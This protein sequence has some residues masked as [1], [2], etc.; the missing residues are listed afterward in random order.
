[1]KVSLRHI[2]TRSAL[3]HWRR[4]SILAGIIFL[5]TIVITGS[6][7]TGYSVRAS[8]KDNNVRRLNGTEFVISSGNRFIPSSLVSRMRADYGLRLE[9]IIETKG[10]IKNFESGRALL[11]INVFGVEDSFFS[12]NPADSGLTLKQGTALVNREMAERLG[13]DSG[14]EI[15]LRTR[16]LSTIPGDSPFAPESDGYESMFLTVAGVVKDAGYENLSLGVSQLTPLNIFVNTRNISPGEDENT[17]VNRIIVRSMNS[18]TS[19]TLNIWLRNSFSPADAGLK[20]REV[21]EPGMMEL[22]SD[23]IFISEPE[24]EA[25]TGAVQG[26]AP[27]ITWLANSL[28]LEGRSVP[29]SFISALPASLYD[30]MPGKGEVLISQWLAEDIAASVGDTLK[31]KYYISGPSG[32]LEERETFFSIAGIT[33]TLPGFGGPHLMPDFP[34][35]SGSSSCRNWDAGVPVDFDRVR[36]KDEEYWNQYSGTP[37]A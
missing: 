9:G 19:D 3:H 34:G 16:S 23:R 11:D 5:L 25:V 37:K 4:N 29:Y 18:V 33:P 10:W 31:M 21:S 30:M 14:D 27:V 6:L 32:N 13:I 8:L 22:I 35:I 15:I 12:F 20:L 26:S 24:V 36:E 28:E 17:L 7:L 2:I 1:M